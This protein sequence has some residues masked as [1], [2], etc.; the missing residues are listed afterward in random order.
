MTMVESFGQRKRDHIEISLREE[1]QA[2]NAQFQAIELQ[3]NPLPEIDF[4]QISLKCEV[5]ANQLRSPL[6]VSS[7]TLGHGGAMAINR[8][9]AKSCA[10]F[11]WMMGVGSQRRQLF[12]SDAANECQQLRREFPELVIFGNIGLS[13]LMECSS[14]Q[15]QQLVDS[16]QAQFLVVHTNPLQEALQREGTPSFSGGREA[17]QRIIS[18]L[19]VPI[20]LKETG[21]GFSQGSLEQI[22]DLPLAAIDISG[23]GGTHWGKIEGLRESKDSLSYQVAETFANW[24]ISTV[25]SLLA[26]K[27]VSLK[28]DIWASGGVRSGLDAAKLLAMGASKVGF[29]M[30]ILRAAMQGEEVLARLM[31]RF[32]FELK[33]AMFCLGCKEL[34]E[35]IGEDKLWIRK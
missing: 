16:L 26:A 32:E 15:I 24:G 1:S 14:Q 4:N 28:C 11:G 3:H 10:S 29:A 13:Q 30:P 33:T 12:D 22:K 25:D 5:F 34:H 17:L 31:R 2:P 18:D 8:I 7:M 6:F 35:L 20:V 27:K 21:C 19:N 23:R 9:L